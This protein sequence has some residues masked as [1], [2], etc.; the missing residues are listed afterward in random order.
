MSSKWLNDGCQFKSEL[1]F[2]TKY[3]NQLWNCKGGGKISTDLMLFFFSKTIKNCQSELI[4]TGSV[5][6]YCQYHYRGLQVTMY[7]MYRA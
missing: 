3:G 1:I 7:T 5:T 4:T 6:T 2:A